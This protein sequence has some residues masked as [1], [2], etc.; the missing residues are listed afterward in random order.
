MVIRYRILKP[1][2]V[3][4][5]NS[6]GVLYADEYFQCSITDVEKVLSIARNIQPDGVTVGICDRAVCT[7][8]IICQELGLPGLDLI[9][10]QKATNKHLMIRAFQEH[11][12]AHPAFQ[13]IYGEELESVKINI[14]YPVISKP[15]DMAGSRG[16]NKIDNELMLMECLRNSMK[17]S[18]SKEIIVEEY[19]EG[20]E[21]SVEL[22]VK[23]GVPMVM[24]ITDKYT[25]GEPHF[26]EIA[27]T[28]PSNLPESIKIDIEKLAVSA[29]V[30]LGIRDGLAHAEIIVTPTGPKMVEI[31]ARMGGDAIQ[32]QL[33]LLSTGINVP[34][35]SIKIALGEDFD[36]PENC[37]NKYSAIK[38]I[39]SKDGVI[40]DIRNVEKAKCIRGV[41]EIELIC[42]IGQQCFRAVDN[43][44]RLGYVI[45]QGDSVDEVLSACDEACELIDIVI[46]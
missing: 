7:A 37:S 25:S 20:P 42:C 15:V 24:Q 43:S 27:H 30:A 40:K 39:Q 12:V 1:L 3:L 26:M 17:S 2:S 5:P 14:P 10:A 16:I 9:T 23:N 32:E 34:E 28:Q 46:G 38:F 36:Y 11:G 31:G 13:R 6:R 8:A 44:G 22:I 33:I 41:K 18:I 35:Y 45:A 21:V 19:M 29:V 4:C